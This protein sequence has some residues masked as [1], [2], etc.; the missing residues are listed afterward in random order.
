MGDSKSNSKNSI[1]MRL[2]RFIASTGHCSR[3]KADELIRSGEVRVNGKT[4]FELGTQIYPFKDAVF[5]EN[6]RLFP[7]KVSIYALLNKP[8]NTLAVSKDELER[9]TVMDLCNGLPERVFPVGRMDALTEGMIIMTNDGDFAQKVTHPE[10][11]VTKTYLV[12]L[13]GQPTPLELGKLKKGVSVIGGRSSALHVE[14]VKTK[15]SSQ[16]DWVKIIIY[17][18]RNEQ[19]HRLFHKIGYD[20]KKMQRV[21]IGN[22]KL[23][24]VERGRYRLMTDED[25]QKV[26]EKPKELNVEKV[27]SKT[28]FSKKTNTNK[29]RFIPRN[30][31]RKP[32]GRTERPRRDRDERDSAERSGRADRSAR[33]RPDRE[34]RPNRRGRPDNRRRD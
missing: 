26:F 18:G 16:Y 24:A 3:R 19:V 31:K 13:N 30:E 10:S 20:V 8:T 34:E 28:N 4:I 6:K 9:Q 21:A 17:E 15:G 11:K 12:K 2:N 33:G 22:L 14:T 29:K 23:G 25:I 7:P 32:F 1:Q 5:A 27:F